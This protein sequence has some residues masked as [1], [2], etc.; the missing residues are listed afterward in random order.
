MDDVVHDSI[1]P[2]R[3][4]L[5]MRAVWLE[6]AAFYGRSCTNPRTVLHYVLYRGSCADPL[7]PVKNTDGQRLPNTKCVLLGFFEKSHFYT[8]KQQQQRE[9]RNNI[10]SNNERWRTRSIESAASGE[11]TCPGD[12]MTRST[13]IAWVHCSSGHLREA[14]QGALLERT[15][16]C[17]IISHFDPLVDTFV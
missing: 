7:E 13:R 12:T 11:E 4:I 9:H 10:R 3:F 17:K 16:S 1:W 2:V 8:R 15:L 6:G 14:S 5:Q